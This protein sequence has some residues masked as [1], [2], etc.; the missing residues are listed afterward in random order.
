MMADIMSQVSVRKLTANDSKVPCGPV[1]SQPSSASRGSREG[2]DLLGNAA[3]LPKLQQKLLGSRAEQRDRSA[4]NG[5]KWA[6][7]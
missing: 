4:M 3:L 6:T 2:Q 1:P 7:L 5:K